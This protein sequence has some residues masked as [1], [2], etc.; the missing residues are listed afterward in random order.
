MILGYL[1]SNKKNIDVERQRQQILQYTAANNLAVDMF[2][3]ESS[4]TKQINGRNTSY[5]VYA[6]QGTEGPNCV[7]FK[8]TGSYAPTW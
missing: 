1:D 5:I 2:V 4:I 3:Q 7:K 8:L 6:Y